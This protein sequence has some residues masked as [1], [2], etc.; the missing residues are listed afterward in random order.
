AELVSRLQPVLDD[1]TTKLTKRTDEQTATMFEKATRAL[2][3]D[4]PT[5]PFAKQ[6]SAFDK[7]YAGLAKQSAPQNEVLT[8]KVDQRTKA[9]EVQ[10]AASAATKA[11]AN[12]T[13]I[14]G[15]SY[16]DNIG[17]VLS[18]L[19]TGFGDEYVS[20]GTTTGAIPRCKKGD[21]VATISGFD[22]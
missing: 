11:A 14:K 9:V 19:A 1:F 3:P 4:D 18:A 17:A 16:E 15:A 20:T 13:P 21:G 7:R 2:N 12:V 6:M 8:A 22:A 10:K 5:S